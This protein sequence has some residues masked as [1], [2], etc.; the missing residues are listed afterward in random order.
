MASQMVNGILDSQN[1]GRYSEK[2]SVRDCGTACV[3]EAAVL[4]W[5]NQRKRGRRRSDYED[6]VLWFPEY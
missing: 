4:N 2:P 5:K 1:S 6:S 3:I